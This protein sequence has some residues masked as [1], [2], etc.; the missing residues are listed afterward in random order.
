MENEKKNIYARQFAEML[1][2]PTVTNCDKELFAKLRDVMWEIAPEFSKLP[3][4]MP[5]NSSLVIKWAGKKSDRPLVLMGHQDV[6]PAEDLSKW[7]YPPYDG[8]IAEDKIWGRGA[9]DCK[10]TVFA[11]MTAANELIKEG[12][13]PEQD[14]YFA[15]GDDEET[16]GGSAIAEAEY[17]KSIGVKPSL[18]LDEGGGMIRREVM[19]KY[20][21]SNVGVI[22]IQEK[23]FS[24][25]KFIA[26]SKGGHSSAPPKNT[27]FIRLARFMLKIERKNIFDVKV[28]P[29]VKEML[30]EF[31]KAV[32]PA[33]LKPFIRYAYMFMPLA[34]RILPPMLA[35]ELKAFLSTTMVFTMAEGSHATNNIPDAAW[36]L[37]NLRYSPQEGH[38]ACME[39]L[40]KLADKYDIEIEVLNTRDASKIADTSSPE[41]KFAADMINKTYGK[42]ILAPY[43]IPG[44]T[45]CRYM[46]DICPTALRFTPFLV[47]IEELS[48]CHAAN[49]RVGVEELS[50][51]VE[52]FRNVITSYK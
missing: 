44:G 23:G 6:V 28:L 43:L 8:V 4:E 32:R 25:I 27:P 35:G 34:V 18:V 48:S 22:G 38:D 5:R 14:I 16:S 40:K 52:F 47:T 46:Q 36:V 13:V 3:R 24:D 2:I 1:K 21:T 17:L 49:E 15:Y 12:F 10:S 33:I 29:I 45:D 50:L 9:L 11:S 7:K 31:S 42:T 37:A 19:E 39:K 20:L 26:R 30:R 51:G 41:Y